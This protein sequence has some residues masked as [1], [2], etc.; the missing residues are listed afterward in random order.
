ME[1]KTDDHRARGLRLE[2]LDRK[3]YF[4]ETGLSVRNCGLVVSVDNGIFASSP[5]GFVGSDGI[6]EIKFPAVPAKE[7]VSRKNDKFL[8][9][10]SMK[11]IRLKRKHKYFYQ[12]VLQLYCTKRNWC[13]FVVDFN[14][15]DETS[16]STDFWCERIFASE[17]TPI[18]AKMYEK[19]EKFYRLDIGDIQNVSIQDTREI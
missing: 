8:E 5:D 3:R 10:S 2:P 12:I 9:F 4:E 16:P 1:F 14:N 7:V 19:L 6:L 13:D 18:M 15:E 17:T 11:K